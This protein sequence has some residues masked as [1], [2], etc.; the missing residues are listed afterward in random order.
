MALVRAMARPKSSGRG[1]WRVP[2]GELLTLFGPSG[3]GQMIV[4]RLIGGFAIPT[5]GRISFDGADITRPPPNRTHADI[6]GPAY[7]LCSHDAR[8]GT[9]RSLRGDGGV[10]ATF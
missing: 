5:G 7:F 4:L 10:S 3:S 6:A 8:Y 2:S 9:A 1:P